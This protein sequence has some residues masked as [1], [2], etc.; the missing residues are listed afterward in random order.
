MAPLRI[1]LLEDDPLDVEL[2]TQ[3]LAAAGIEARVERAASRDEFARALDRP[4]P[5]LVLSDYNI[6]GWS[7][8]EALEAARARWGGLPFVFVTGSIGDE[9]AVEALLAGATDLVL[10]HQLARLGPAVR[11]AVAEST[12][13]DALGDAQAAL[14]RSEERFRA[15][16]ENSLDAT[17][18]VDM[19]ARI[20]YASPAVE[21]ITGHRVNDRVGRSCLEFVHPDDLDDVRQLL[22]RCGSTAGSVLRSELRLRNAEGRWIEVEFAVANHLDNAAIGAIVINYHDVSERRRLEEMLRQA[23]KMEA[24]GRVAGGIAHDFNNL[25]GVTMGY[26]DLI[27]RRMGEQDPLR[28]KVQE[29]RKAAERAGTLTQQ[30]MAF[31]RRRPPMAETLDVSAVVTDVADMLQRVLGEDVKLVLRLG[32]ETLVRA[33]RSQVGQVLM[34]LAVNA[35]DAMPR[36]GK[37]IIECRNVELDRP[38]QMRRMAAAGPYVLLSVTDTGVGMEPEVQ[39]H[40][41][42]PFF[43]T[44]PPGQGTGLGLATVYG[45]VTQTGGH[46]TV[47]SELRRGTSFK[48]YLPRVAADGQVLAAQAAPDEAA[49]GGSETVLL[50]EDAEAMRRMTREVLESAGYSVL[51][52]GSGEEALRVAGLHQSRIDLLLTDLVMPDMTGRELA[53][54]LRVAE[55]PLRILYMSGY[56]DE[57]AVQRGELPAGSSFLQKPF[58]ADY[59][60]QAVRRALDMP[61]ESADGLPQPRP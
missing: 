26:S 57:A 58:S 14:R 32:A 50:V 6:P 19:G 2:A 20:L 15:L 27:L 16:V 17:L 34:N 35:R 59:L 53:G 7:G 21:R 1:L 42:E 23:Q 51:D 40:L 22:A 28:P 54:W 46:I 60:L 9:A 10:K 39:Q 49:D 47:Y 48:I 13:R 45:I 3:A 24:I 31:T 56:S 8:R 52:A 44:K 12:Q 36:G 43:T 55:P 25:L 38:T 30:L 5:D 4:R 29:I 18:M 41:F 37:L 61:V 11:R 33:D